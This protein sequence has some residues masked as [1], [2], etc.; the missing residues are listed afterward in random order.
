MISVYILDHTGSVDRDV[1]D[2]TVDGT[3]IIDLLKLIECTIVMS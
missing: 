3:V 1:Q 2:M